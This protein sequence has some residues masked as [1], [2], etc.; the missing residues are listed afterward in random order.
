MSSMDKLIAHLLKLKQDWDNGLDA[1]IK[2][3]GLCHDLYSFVTKA[4][5]NVI[6]AKYASVSFPPLVSPSS[7]DWSGPSM[8]IDFDFIK[9][10]LRLLTHR[11]DAIAVGIGSLCAWFILI[12]KD[13]KWIEEESGKELTHE[14]LEKIL[15][16]CV[17]DDS[18][19]FENK[20]L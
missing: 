4:L 15:I 8:Q 2:A 13:S 9:V 14:L 20:P 11:K 12:H 10:D 7:H 18:S 16:Y 19:M 3:S 1:R 6:D 5:E 17:V